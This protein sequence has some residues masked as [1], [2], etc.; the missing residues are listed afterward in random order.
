MLDGARSEIDSE[1][2]D[3]ATATQPHAGPANHEL[4]PQ[5]THQQLRQL[6]Q[7]EGQQQQ[8]QHLDRMTPR[9]SSC[10]ANGQSYR[11]AERCRYTHFSAPS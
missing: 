1:A 2:R 4:L 7:S 5:I 3:T 6:N 11:E 10:D 9:H 8:Q